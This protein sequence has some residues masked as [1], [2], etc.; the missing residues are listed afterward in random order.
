MG[1]DEPERR[2]QYHG[3]QLAQPL[4]A[5]AGEPGEGEAVYQDPHSKRFTVLRFLPEHEL[6]RYNSMRCKVIAD[7]G[8]L[9]PFECMLLPLESAA[10]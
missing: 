1:G 9:L 6:Y 4:Q 10:A 5:S 7:A 8:N 3:L 2:R